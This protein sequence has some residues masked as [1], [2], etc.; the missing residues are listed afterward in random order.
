MGSRTRQIGTRSAVQMAFIC[1]IVCAILIIAV[2]ATLY[3][4]TEDREDIPDASQ[5]NPA[6]N[7]SKTGPS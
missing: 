5:P 6:E 2:A 7:S 3:V 1:V 4:I